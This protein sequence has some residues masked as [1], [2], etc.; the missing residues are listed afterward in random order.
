M[1]GLEA[2]ADDALHQVVWD[3]ADEL[4]CGALTASPADAK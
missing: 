3:T 2:L 4:P 1:S